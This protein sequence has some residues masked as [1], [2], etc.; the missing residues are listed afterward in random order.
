VHIGK[1]VYITPQEPGSSCDLI[2]LG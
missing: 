1:G 2:A